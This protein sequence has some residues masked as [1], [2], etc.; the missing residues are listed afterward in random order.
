MRPSLGFALDTGTD[1]IVTMRSDGIAERAGFLVGDVI[2][3][4][5]GAEPIAFLASAWWPREEKPILARLQRHGRQLW[6]VLAFDEEGGAALASSVPEPPAADVSPFTRMFDRPE[7]PL[8]TAL[9][10]LVGVAPGHEDL[11][12]GAM[13]P[14]K[15]PA[16]RAAVRAALARAA[17]MKDRPASPPLMGGMARWY[18]TN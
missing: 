13:L 2:L 9:T 18:W 17:A 7:R 15:R 14:N 8:P 11:L 16:D 10:E 6:R 4:L 3:E 5:D 1:E 12:G